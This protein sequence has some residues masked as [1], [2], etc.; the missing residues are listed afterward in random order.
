MT[1]ALVG[2][3]VALLAAGVCVAMTA[4]FVRR[5]SN[6]V[7]AP[8]RGHH[9]PR[10]AVAHPTVVHVLPPQQLVVQQVPLMHVGA[11]APASRP[12]QAA[13]PG[14]HLQRPWPGVAEAL[15][16]HLRVERDPIDRMRVAMDLGGLGGARPASLLLDAVRDGTISPAAGAEAISRTGFEGGVIAGAA[17]AEPDP[18]VRSLAQLVLDGARTERTRP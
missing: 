9:A 16:H 5:E 8:V 6:A 13:Q 14:V 2:A 4:W 17:M 7:P 18:R 12:H 3:A 10:A 15:G 1:L 11:V